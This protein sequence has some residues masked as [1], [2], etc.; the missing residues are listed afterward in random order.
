MASLA[1]SA[2][3][4]FGVAAVV[5]SALAVALTPG[6]LS[7]LVSPGF[8]MPHRHCYLDKPGM[9][10]LQG[11]SD[12]LIGAAYMA[13]SGALAYLVWKARQDVP[14]EWMFLAFGLFIF[15]CGWTHFMEVWTL[16]HPTYWLSGAIKAV[17]AAA[18]L[19]T[20]AGTF[21]LLPR[22][23]GLIQTA[24]ASAQRN[25]EQLRLQSAALESAANAI[26]ITDRQGTIEWVN[27]AFE[28]LTGYSVHE[29]RGQNHRL[30]QSGKQDP[31]GY[32]HLWETISA[33]RVWHGEL[34][35]RRKDGGQYNEEMTIT[36]LRDAS[37][38][39]AHY[40]AVKLDV[41][42]RKRSERALRES[43]Q[44]FRQLADAMPQI[45]WAA[46]PD[47][48]LDYFNRKWTELAGAREGQTGEES[49]LPVLHPEDRQRCMEAW[50]K[51]VR[52]GEPY[53][54][55][56]RFMD[57]R[58]GTYRWHLGRALPAR[59]K[60]GEIL[61]WYGTSTD[62]D[63]LKQT[64]AALAEARDK[65]EQ[66]VA[67]RTAQLVEANS[68][69][70][71]FAYTAA[72][73]LRSPLRS[74]SSF[75]SIVMED[76]GEK[77]GPE[78]QSF[79][80]RVTGAASQMDRLL[81]DLLE[82]SRMSQA[83]MTLEPVSLHR[84]VRE[85]LVLLEGDIRAR[86]AE[87]SVMEPLPEVTGHLATVVLLVNNL[88]SN[89]LKFVAA[90]VQPKVRVSAE[91]KD[92]RVRLWIQDNGIGIA[93]KNAGKIFAAFHRLHSKQAYPGTGLGLAIVRKG[94]ER[95]GGTV[96]VESELGKGS[97]FWVELPGAAA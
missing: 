58:S 53:Q 62:I 94:A 93:G 61:R 89:A 88:V 50:Y 39:I 22:A 79:L 60:R 11:L 13:I 92:G 90:D 83:E 31:A 67:E 96:G 42:E 5:V 4:R 48:H 59:N 44:R 51:S 9:L 32:K 69:L 55:E 19:A 29:L 41:T 75:S 10:W 1:R 66:A 87:V 68:N 6:L 85:A 30:L 54:V 40:I 2:L 43:E 7:A 74:I 52:S 46:R 71:N 77:L 27:P 86:N 63:D 14:F 23:F 3:V 15:S 12:F 20:A 97:R 26:S 18:S 80:E 64:Q 49:W 84:A 95:M 76:Y 24:K 35:N 8:F 70:Q 81:T 45:V 21:Y 17:T 82:Y 34:V 28:R 65:L 33:G 91:E 73:D 37:G 47:G 57:P 78:G 36:P 72:H 56:Y 16:W 38:E 25:Q